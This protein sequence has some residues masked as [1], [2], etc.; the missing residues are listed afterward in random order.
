[1]RCLDLLLL[2]GCLCDHARRWRGRPRPRRGSATVGG[3]I[4]KAPAAADSANEVGAAETPV[5]HP[6][7][8]TETGTEVG[9]AAGS[10][11]EVSLEGQPAHPVR[12]VYSFTARAATEMSFTVG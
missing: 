11:T 7:A 5:A 2:R 8:A 6:V 1:M 10:G 4:A 9:A 3:L 12:A